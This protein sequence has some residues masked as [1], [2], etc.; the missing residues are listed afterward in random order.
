MRFGARIAALPHTLIEAETD[1][2]IVEI[3]RNGVSLGWHGNAVLLRKDL[4]V[5]HSYRIALPG[6]EPRGAVRIDLDLGAG[7]TVVAT[8]LGL[9]RRDRH[10]QLSTLRA[11]TAG[12]AHSVIA[13]D[14]NEWS[15]TKGMEPL[16][17]K[18][19]THAPGRS[20]HARRPVVALDRFAL[21][22][23]LQLHDAG[24]EQGAI[25]RRASDHLPIWADISVPATSAIC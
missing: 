25:A 23:R 19:V 20:F 16:A 21:T 7:L 1:F 5:L 22:D 8:H 2:R 4:E 18:F 14:F 11:A 13:G 9:L 12:I 17:D 6:L 3:A 10:A 15:Q 24:V